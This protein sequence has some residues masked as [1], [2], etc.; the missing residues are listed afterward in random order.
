MQDVCSS[1]TA[2]RDDREVLTELGHSLSR[3]AGLAGNVLSTEC[4]TFAP[5]ASGPQYML[6]AAK[7]PVCLLE[8]DKAWP[9]FLG[10]SVIRTVILARCSARD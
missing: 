1:I 7:A 3:R 9:V 8:L 10:L 2:I 4:T 6:I 5:Q